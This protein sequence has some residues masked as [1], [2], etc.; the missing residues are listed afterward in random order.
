MPFAHNEAIHHEILNEPQFESDES[1]E[2]DDDLAFKENN[3]KLSC[4]TSILDAMQ[5]TINDMNKNAKSSNFS[6]AS[7]L[8][9]G[10]QSI[11]GEVDGLQDDFVHHAYESDEEREKLLNDQLL[12]N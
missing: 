4:Q 10:M 9:Q 11:H 5:K 6:F 7:K 2:M 1:F 3:D 12:S 8:K